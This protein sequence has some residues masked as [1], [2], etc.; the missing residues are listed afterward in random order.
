MSSEIKFF[1]HPRNIRL[2]M[3]GIFASEENYLFIFNQSSF[4]SK[5]PLTQGFYH[6]S[7]TFMTIPQSSK[8]NHIEL[9]ILVLALILAEEIQ[10]H[11]HF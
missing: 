9:N 2:L 3:G 6:I 4:F 8:N 1:L 11:C 10:M 5:L 7:S